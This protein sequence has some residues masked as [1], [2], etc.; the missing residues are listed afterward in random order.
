MSSRYEETLARTDFHIEVRN[1][2]EQRKL[3]FIH[4]LHCICKKQD[5][6]SKKER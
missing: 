6:K 3:F 2:L 5:E 4:C 1:R